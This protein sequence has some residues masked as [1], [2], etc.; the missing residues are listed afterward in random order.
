MHIRLAPTSGSWLL[1]TGGERIQAS[2]GPSSWPM[3]GVR[4]C[5]QVQCPQS[6]R[7]NQGSLKNSERMSGQWD[8]FQFF[9]PKK[10]Q[11][12]LICLL[13]LASIFSGF[14]KSM[15]NLS[16][17]LSASLPY[18]WSLLELA[19]AAATAAEDHPPSISTAGSLFAARENWDFAA[20]VLLHCFPNACNSTLHPPL[21][22]HS[23]SPNLKLLPE[24]SLLERKSLRLRFRPGLT[25]HWLQWSP[26][27]CGF[28]GIRRNF[29]VQTSF[30]QLPVKAMII[31]T[32]NIY[33]YADMCRALC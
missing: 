14:L 12:L 4:E 31:I 32:T 8:A 7:R 20:L 10:I 28:H 6:L 22:P 18:F 15:A 17:L 19:A 30:A 3:S 5:S 11:F 9:P 26:A 13:V 27:G 24:A 23:F 16:S 2:N 21:Y 25:Q 33:K 1:C 29:L